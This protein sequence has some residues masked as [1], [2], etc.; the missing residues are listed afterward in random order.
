MRKRQKRSEDKMINKEIEET[1]TPR[2]GEI[3]ISK[4]TEK[5]QAGK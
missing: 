1:K 2:D 3:Q 5:T 4:L